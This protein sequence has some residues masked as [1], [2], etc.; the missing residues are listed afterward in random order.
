MPVSVTVLAADE[1]AARISGEYF[2]HM[3]RRGPNSET[4]DPALQEQLLSRYA[5]LT[6][7]PFPSE[8]DR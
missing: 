2:Y 8:I 6:T 3:E 4:H 7:L 1:A 5:K